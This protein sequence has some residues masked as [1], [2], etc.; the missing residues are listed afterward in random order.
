MYNKGSSSISR[1]SICLGKQGWSSFKINWRYK[2]GA[3]GRCGARPY[4]K[5]TAL[6][7]HRRSAGRRPHC[8]PCTDNSSLRDTVALGREKAMVSATDVQ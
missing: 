2:M 3:G 6:L 5:R 8:S 1:A 7:N 4:Q